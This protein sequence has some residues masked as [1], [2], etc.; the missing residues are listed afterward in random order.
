MRAGAPKPDIGSVDAFRRALLDARS[1]AYTSAA[2]SGV[3]F[4]GVVDRLGI[5]EQVRAKARTRP[6]GLIGELLVSGE[7]EC[8]VQHIPELLAVPGIDLV[9]PLPAELQTINL[10]TI[11]VVAA[12]TQKD[13][14]QAL[15]ELMF[16]GASARVFEANGYE[17][18][19]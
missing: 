5:A 18:C 2:A 17:M 1:I 8:A 9:G 14:A 6:D 10:K 16:S 19:A 13:K 4:A 11:S 15:L 3:Y 12:S 7:A